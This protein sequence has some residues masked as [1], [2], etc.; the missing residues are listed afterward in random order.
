MLP[1]IHFSRLLCLS[2]QTHK[3]P[4]ASSQQK[5]PAHTSLCMGQRPS[6]VLGVEALTFP[7]AALR[8][9][10]CFHAT[11]CTGGQG[12][13]PAH[14]T[15]CRS[16]YP[17]RGVQTKACTSQALSCFPGATLSAAPGLGSR[18]GLRC[19]ACPTALPHAP[20]HCQQ[21][22]AS[23]QCW[24]LRGLLDQEKDMSSHFACGTENQIQS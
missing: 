11:A 6:P 8:K 5:L 19:L 17:E 2:L 13:H 16:K 18:E 12:L 3:P 14:R 22:L 24:G 7:F 21:A 4:K 10:N 23:A 20:C 15:P 9:I 1:N